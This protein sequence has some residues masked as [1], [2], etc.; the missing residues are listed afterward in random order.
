LH[1]KL[2][3]RVAEIL[4]RYD[5]TSP[6]QR[7][8]VG[9]SGGADS[10]ALLHI[11]TRLAER[12]AIE[13][14]VLHVN[15][16]L[17]GLESEEDQEFVTQLA[18]SLGVRLV[19]YREDIRNK[20]NLEQTTRLVRRQFF[21]R[22]LEEKIADRIALG[23]NRGDQAETVLFRLLRGSGTAGLAGMRFISEGWLVRPLL[24]EPRSEI[25]S[26]AT[27]EG[28]AWRQDSSNRDR[29]FARNRLRLDVIPALTAGFNSNLEAILAGTARV[30]QDEEAYWSAQVQPIFQRAVRRSHFGWIVEV[31]SLT[32]AHPAIQRRLV[33]RILAEVRGD[34]RAL[35]VSHIEGILAICRSGHGHDRV[36]VPGVDVL[37]SFDGLLF[38]P[39][40]AANSEERYY[41][42]PITLGKSCGLPFHAGLLCLEGVDPGA[43]KCAN[44]KEDSESGGETVYLD[45]DALTR[46]ETSF[47]L[48]VRNW[49]PGDQIHRPGRQGAEKLKSLFQENRVALWERRHW[50]VLTVGGAIVWARQFGCDVRFSAPA[51]CPSR[52]RLKYRPCE[53]PLRVS[54]S[55]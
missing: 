16:Q 34:M 42:E 21:R 36:I 51:E 55:R 45:G 4:S 7:I 33:R 54:Q 52:V 10:V 46:A 13:P 48:R 28:L 18:G 49:E 27:G 9:V 15:H 8:G 35:D 38:R 11:L 12:F 47:P 30:A 14:V 25:R 50:P 17:R 20:G 32:T 22:C 2:P 43:E 37:R 23:H 39:V 1:P 40:T 41:S 26:W 3:D 6:G 24:A 31:S 44:F 29:R 19:I 53:L 5:M